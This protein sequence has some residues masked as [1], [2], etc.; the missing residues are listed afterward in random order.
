MEIILKIG[1][2]LFKYRSFTPIPLIL[3]VFIFFKPVID[4]DMD[5]ILTAIGL[6]VLI[7]GEYI[8]ILSVG[9]SFSGTSGRE[10]FLR[11]DNL[12]VSGIYSIV[13]NPLYIGNLL[14]YTGLLI[15]YSNF[16]ALLF[17]DLLL[18]LQYF[19]I[20]RAEESYLEKTYGEEY[21][22]Y[23][24][25][26]YSIFPLF[27]NYIKPENKFN[28]LKVLLKENDSVFNALVIFGLIILYKGYIMSGKIVYWKSYAVYFGLL[29]ICYIFI[30]LIKKRIN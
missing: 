19:F 3:I 10:N 1:N 29:I 14:I 9:Y 16:Y 30:K 15:V 25:S 11:A 18:I 13:R 23:K 28:P 12:N 22:K 7:F 20:I 4:S 27:S 5:N 17:F 24:N 6:L 21:K 8:R 2:F 26:V